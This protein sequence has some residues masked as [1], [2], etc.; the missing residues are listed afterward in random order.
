LLRDVL[1]E[2]GAPPLTFDMRIGG[3]GAP[4]MSLGAYGPR[5]DGHDFSDVAAI[6]IRCM[7]PNTLPAQPPVLNQ[8]SYCDY[9]GDFIKEQGFGSATYSFFTDLA[10]AGK[11]VIN[12]LSTYADHDT[13][14]QFYEKLR[15]QQFPVPKTLTTNDPGRALEFVANHAEVVVKPSVGVGSTRL[16]IAQDRERL[17]QIRLCPLMMQERIR[18]DTLRINIVGD[19]VVLAL[20]VVGSGETTDSRTAPRGF[21]FVKLPDEEEERIVRANRAL[22]LHYA[23]WDIIEANDGRYVYLDCNPGPYILWTGPEFS[24]AV[25]EQLAQYMLTYARTG[26]VTQ[27][28]AAVRPYTGRTG[29]A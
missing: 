19:S 21:E 4:L 7:T 14:A 9:R 22:G 8:S 16:F 2:K 23:A 6:Y 24:R 10:A 5:W 3:D 11:L 13:K 15:A 1:V 29:I 28:S 26:S 25:M 12:E 27:A 20:R 18:G 17:D